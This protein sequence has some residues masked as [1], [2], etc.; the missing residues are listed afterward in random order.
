MSRFDEVAKRFRVAPGVEFLS[1]EQC[2]GEMALIGIKH[3]PPSYA[4]AKRVFG[5]SRIEPVDARFWINIANTKN[6]TFSMISDREILRK[7]VARYRQ[8]DGKYR[9]DWGPAEGEGAEE[10][11]NLDFD[12]MIPLCVNGECDLWFVWDLARISGQGEPRVIGFDL[13]MQ[14]LHFSL[15]DICELYD[16]VADKDNEFVPYERD[17]NGKIMLVPL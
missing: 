10:R 5:N 9:F 17:A 7:R 11:K 2:A 15:P 1:P 16:R 14:S 4:W 12:R 3:V 13:G 6:E 8:P